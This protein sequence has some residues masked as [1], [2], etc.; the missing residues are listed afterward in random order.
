M[1]Q[2]H[3]G[4]CLFCC[5]LLPVHFRG[6]KFDL[7]L[8]EHNKC[9]YITRSQFQ[10]FLSLFATLLAVSTQVIPPSQNSTTSATDNLNSAHYYN[11]NFYFRDES[12]IQHH[13]TTFG[14]NVKGRL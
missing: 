13:P 8:S 1:M 3:W 5:H 12:M 9:Q 4:I 11:H 7:Y 10:L 6:C 2:I 14:N